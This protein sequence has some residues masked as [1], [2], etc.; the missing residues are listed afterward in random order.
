VN[1]TEAITLA[2]IASRRNIPFINV[3]YPNDAGVRNNPNYVVLNSTLYTHCAAIYKFIQKTYPLSDVVFFRKK[4]TQEDRLKNYFEEI[5]KSTAS[6]PLKIKYVV[7]DNTFTPTDL[8]KHLKREANTVC[9]AG[10]LD[11]AFGQVL[12]QQLAGLLDNYPSVVFGMPNW[13]EGADFAAPEYKDIEVIYTTP[14]YLAPQSPLVNSMQNTFK[15][16]YYV[17][18]TEMA[19][20]GFETVYHFGR[21]LSATGPNFASSLGDERFRIFTDFDIQPVLDGK[22]MTLNYFENKKIYMIKKVNGE[23]TAVF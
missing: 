22:T 5:A 19:Y 17:K 14:F 4:G 2:G 11:L 16:I 7:L 23:V 21:L 18:P 10:S 6:V 1:G 13:W 12:T 15:S 3:N 8:R 9:I 20:K